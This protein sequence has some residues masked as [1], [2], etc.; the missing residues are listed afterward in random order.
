MLKKLLK[1]SP[2]IVF[3]VRKI[4]QWKNT[5]ILDTDIK[6]ETFIA[7]KFKKRLGYDIEF[8]KMPETFNQKIQFRK[9]YDHNP[10]YS[11]CADK[12]KVR[13][14]VKAFRKI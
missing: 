5:Y 6:K 3:L 8:N 12:Y 14:Y 7:I 2:L 9:L 4:V 13:E 11:I 1:K 10:L